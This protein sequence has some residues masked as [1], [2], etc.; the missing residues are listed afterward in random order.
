MAAHS[1]NNEGLCS[2]SAKET[3]H[4]ADDLR[5][6]GNAAASDSHCHTHARMNLRFKRFAVKTI[7][8]DGSNIERPR[9]RITLK[10]MEHLRQT[11][12]HGGNDTRGPALLEAKPFAG[13]WLHILSSFERSSSLSLTI[14]LNRMF[15]NADKESN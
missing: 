2:I 14:V 8:E 7:A 10:E 4:K 9:R 11:W 1:G 12:K 6:V 5:E 3:D 13:S 15:K